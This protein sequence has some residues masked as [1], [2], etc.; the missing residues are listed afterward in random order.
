MVAAAAIALSCSVDAFSASFAYGGGKIKIP[1]LS[2][3][4][5]NL[6]CS[7]VLGASLLAGT[8]VRPFLPEMLTVWI[9]FGILFILGSIK[10]LDS[11]TKSIIRKY[12]GINRQIKFSMFNFKFILSLYANPEKAD[13]DASRSISPGEAAALAVSLSLDGIGVGFGAALGSVS[14]WMVI[15]ASL[16]FNMIAISSG[17]FLG[18]RVSR[19]VPFNASWIGGAILIAMAFVGLLT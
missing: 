11:I 17:C 1:M 14:V 10:L 2:N 9:S 18:E 16:L 12:S 4:I 13:V 3:H 8:L 15:A 7:L 19:R 6:T 5:I